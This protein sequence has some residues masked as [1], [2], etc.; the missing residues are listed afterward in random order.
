MGENYERYNIN[1][2]NKK[3]VSYYMLRRPSDKK[4]ISFN[5]QIKQKDILEVGLGYGYYTAFMLKNKCNIVGAD[6]N[7]DMGKHLGIPIIKANANNLKNKVKADFDYIISIFMTE[8]LAKD[9][10]KS[11]LSDSLFLLRKDGCLCTTIIV[12]KGWGYLYALL[13]NLRGIKKYSY[14]M[15][16]ITDIL[17]IICNTYKLLPLKGAFRVPLAVLVKINE[18]YE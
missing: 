2:Y 6:I 3:G 16:E 8:Y 14:S 18:N 9:E 12:R 7:P 1:Q 11:F 15:K 5:E 10:L 17:E 4:I 13:A